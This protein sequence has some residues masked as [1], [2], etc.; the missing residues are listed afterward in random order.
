VGVEVIFDDAPD[1]PP[2][3]VDARLLFGSRLEAR[4][5][6]DD[7]A[8]RPPAAARARALADRAGRDLAGVADRAGGLAR[9]Y[10]GKVSARVAKARETEAP[11]LKQLYTTGAARLK[12]L[13][14]KRPSSASPPPA[15][16][17]AAASP[18]P[19]PPPIAAAA[20]DDDDSEDELAYTGPGASPPA[21]RAPS[22][23]VPPPPRPDLL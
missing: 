15:D 18:P 21:P 23:P 20:A 16:D 9:G 14:A 7:D 6:D 5:D 2:R 13:A 12:A 17:P 22:P 19:L 1:A 8:A 11:K 4:A 3:L 10:A